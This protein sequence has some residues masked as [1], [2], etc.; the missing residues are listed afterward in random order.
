M[1]AAVGHKMPDWVNQGFAEYTKRMPRESRIDLIEIK[2][3]VRAGGK[4]TEQVHELERSRI[5]AAL[6]E[7]CERVVL[8]E[9]GQNWSTLEL[10]EKLTGWMAGGRDVAFVIGGADGLHPE[11]KRRGQLWSLSRLTL[12]HGLVRVVLAEQLYRA[13]TVIQHHPYHRE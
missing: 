12:P 9:R 4:T 7:N 1:I 13:V 8:D 5:E 2:P 6:P 11:I 3:A 10:A